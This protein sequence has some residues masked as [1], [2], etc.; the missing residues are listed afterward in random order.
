MNT[1]LKNVGLFCMYL[2]I[3][4]KSLKWARRT[5]TKAWRGPLVTFKSLQ[6]NAT[7]ENVM[8]VKRY[9]LAI[10]SKFCEKKIRNCFFA[11]I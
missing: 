11:L 8:I 5:T 4:T 10:F 7:G 9:Y 3:V 6:Q 1:S 2:A